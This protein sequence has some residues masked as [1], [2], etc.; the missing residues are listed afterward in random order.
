M[1]TLRIITVLLFVSISVTAVAQQPDDTPDQ[2]SEEQTSDR[3]NEQQNKD[4]RLEEKVIRAEA[5]DDLQ[6]LL[7]GGRKT[8]VSPETDTN[9]SPDSASLMEHVPGANVADSGPISSQTH[10][11]GMFGPRMNTRVDGMYINPGGPNWMDPPLH[12]APMPL[13]DRLEVHR[14]IAPV[15]SG[16]ESIGGSVNAITKSSDFTE[17]EEYQTGIDTLLR[18]RSVDD[19]FSGGG[20]ASVANNRNRFHLFE[21]TD[22]GDDMEFADGEIDASE[23]ERH[24]FGGG[25]GRRIGAHHQFSI[26]V[27]R[28]DTNES[29][30]P[31]L[32][33][34]IQY[35]DTDIGRV[36]YTGTW[37]NLEIN[38]KLYASTVD[39]EMDNFSLRPAPD[40]NTMMNPGPA[41]DGEDR[42]IIQADS[43]GLGLDLN[44]RFPLGPGDVT[45][46]LNLHRA[47]HEA[48]VFD[49]DSAFFVSPFNDIE[50]HRYSIFG[51]WA[52]SIGGG[53]NMQ[54]GLRLTYVDMKAGEGKAGDTIPNGGAT[55]P[56]L[57]RLRNQFNSRDRTEE[58]FLV[59]A[60]GTFSRD[61]S[62]ET[63][64]EIGGGR[65][66][67]AP[68]YLE[69]FSWVPIES[70]AGLADGNNYVGDV[71]LDPEVSH[72]VD[73]G[74]NWED[75]QDRARLAPRVF[76]RDV[77]DYITGV[78]FDD[79]PN[80]NDS[81]VETVSNVNGDD[82]PLRWDNTD[83]E[84]Y[85]LD[86]Q[87]M[88][89]FTDHL[90][91][92]GVVS[93]MVG[94]NTELDDDV[95]RVPPL[96][97]N[98][99]LT[100]E[101]ETWSVRLGSEFAAE[102]DRISR[103]NV[104]NEADT[105]NDS[106]SGYALVNLSASWTPSEGIRISAGIENL[107]DKEYRRH[108]SG[109]NRVSGSDVDQGER[110]PGAGRNFF[111]SAAIT[112]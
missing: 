102:Q 16:P 66:T 50:R 89:R 30:N 85:G 101:R 6:P 97:G 107:F 56:P 18:G 58:D 108:L 8:N 13:L 28:T 29:G 83:A 1:K 21:S 27:Q 38:G 82:D 93:Y 11:R 72:V 26:N 109:F 59:D 60:T 19:G 44:G 80:T 103:V 25:Y 7:S 17:T 84:F 96:N 20:I 24:T 98:L 40:L 5:P 112:F 2:S 37:E 49:P 71:G 43:Q 54:G 69:R 68:S 52:G 79:T 77:Q 61:L 41:F 4:R 70:T 94:R 36:D 53:W 63:T 95:W 47:D 78:P 75:Q 55:P 105:S 76:Y 64:I 57:E 106:T 110:L 65:K 67:R 92:N 15:S 46:G 31:Q 86:L 74:L 73:V 9:L 111:L 3:E 90:K 34:D 99:G 88:Y 100:Y 62:E 51:E 32:P 22:V 12:Y 35:L 42:R 45:V 81:A 87:G 23:H 104:E 39:H 48:E 10:Y 33:M 91:L 14:G